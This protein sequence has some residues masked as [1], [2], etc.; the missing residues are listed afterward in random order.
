[1][2]IRVSVGPVYVSIQSTQVG[3]EVALDP[4]GHADSHGIALGGLCEESLEVLL[5]QRI[6]RRQGGTAPAVE[7]MTSVCSSE[8]YQRSETTSIGLSFPML[9][10][11]S[12]KVER[13]PSA[14]TP[15]IDLV[16]ST[17][18]SPSLSCRR[19]VAIY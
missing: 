16:P 12:M 10:A 14:T 11:G 3:P 17:S 13:V 8:A 15:S 18:V 6:E 1:M 5:D 4:C 2:S 19:Q 9:P 7:L